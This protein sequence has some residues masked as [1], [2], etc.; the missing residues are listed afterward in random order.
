M[1]RSIPFT[2]AFA[3]C[4]ALAPPS[5]ADETAA[6]VAKQKQAA[7]SNCKMLQPAPLA[8]AESASF[9]LYG[10]VPESRLKGLATTLER[11]LATAAKGLQL[12][13]DARPWT[14]KLAVYVIADRSQFRSFVRQIEK[15]S[16]DD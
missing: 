11:H 15:R 12:E 2:V 5:V 3:L 14:G 7:E 4:V 13:K 6:A 9:L 1:C 8:R 16:P 10:S